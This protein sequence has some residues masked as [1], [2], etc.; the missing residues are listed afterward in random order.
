MEWN[1]V[2]NILSI[3]NRKLKTS[4]PNILLIENYEIVCMYAYR[5]LNA[6]VGGF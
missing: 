4:M 3:V 5:S 1:N 2:D 6:S